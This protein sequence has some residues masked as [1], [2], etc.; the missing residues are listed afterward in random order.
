MLHVQYNIYNEFYHLTSL[1]RSRWAISL[2][3][4]SITPPL[5]LHLPPSKIM[6]HYTM[7]GARA[8]RNAVW[9]LNNYL[10]KILSLGL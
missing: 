6:M 8:S 9:N 4:H 2:R 7:R 10:N 5:P 3:T 1:T